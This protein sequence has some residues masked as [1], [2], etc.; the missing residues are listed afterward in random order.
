MNSA[1]T[2]RS[3]CKPNKSLICVQK[4]VTAIPLVKPVVTG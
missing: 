4:I 2:A 1:G 3:I